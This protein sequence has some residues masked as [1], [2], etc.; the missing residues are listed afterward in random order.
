MNLVGAGRAFIL[1]G[2]PGIT[3]AHLWLILTDPD[4]P[5]AGS[6][7]AVMVVTTRPHTDKTV[8]LEAGEHSFVRHESNVDYGVARLFPTRRLEK[9]IRDGR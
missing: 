7:V 3:E 2:P 1:A 9:A 6:V 5:P 4:P 8:T